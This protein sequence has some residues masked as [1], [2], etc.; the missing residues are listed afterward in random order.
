[1]LGLAW[2]DIRGDTVSV[3]AQLQRLKP[4]QGG[5]ARGWARTRP[6]AARK[7]TTIAID[8]DTVTQLERNRIRQ[9]QARTPEWRYFGLVFV[10]PEGN[11]YHPSTVLKAFHAA[12]DRAA[13][14]RRRIHD[15][16]HTSNRLMKDIGIAQDERMARLGH[17]AEDMN[18]RYGGASEMADRTAV[19]RLARAISG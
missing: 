12:C 9:A 19:D 2:D 16:R 3:S 7:L 18:R 15:L 17:D 8:A 4:E 10:T 14:R 5:D 13:V 11:P 1:M 6:K